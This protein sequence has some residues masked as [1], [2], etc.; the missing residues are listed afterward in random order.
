MPE[1][2]SAQVMSRG[3]GRPAGGTGLTR[4]DILNA[5]L[6]LLADCTAEPELWLGI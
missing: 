5:G 2:L 6:A 4:G 1:V 3:R